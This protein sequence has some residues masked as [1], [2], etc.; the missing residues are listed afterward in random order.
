[1]AAVRT[2]VSTG[3]P[4]LVP[5]QSV[6]VTM[7]DKVSPVATLL[8]VAEAV[9]ALWELMRATL[10]AATVVLEFKAPYQAPQLTTLV[11]AVVMVVGQRHPALGA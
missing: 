5:E 3:R 6:K 11:V 8:A 10:L 1:M 2:I 9:L 7:V 4:T